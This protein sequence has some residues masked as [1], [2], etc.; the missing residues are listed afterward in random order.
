[1][2]SLLALVLAASF[3]SAETLPFTLEGVER[4]FDPSG[5]LTSERQW[6]FAWN[7]AGSY[8]KVD[9]TPNGRAKG[10]LRHKNATWDRDRS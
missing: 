1:M 3:C 4:R 5:R 7:Q 10:D 8:V 6:L 2:R 9:L